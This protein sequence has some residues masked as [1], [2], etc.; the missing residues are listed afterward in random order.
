VCG[1]GGGGYFGSKKLSIVVLF[2]VLGGDATFKVAYVVRLT[3]VQW[4]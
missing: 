2:D 1:G 3:T 4:L